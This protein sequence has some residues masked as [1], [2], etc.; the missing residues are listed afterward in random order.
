MNG[1]RLGIYQ[2]G[3]NFGWTKNSNGEMSTIRNVILA[4]CK[5]KNNHF[6]GR[7]F[8]ILILFLRGRCVWFS[9]RY[10]M[11]FGIV[12]FSQLCTYSIGTNIYIRVL[13]W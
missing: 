10:P 8:P 9:Y 5:H 4:G 13:F 6:L 2:T 11:V 7:K 1:V 12:I 3:T